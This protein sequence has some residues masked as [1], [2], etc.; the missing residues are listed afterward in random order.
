LTPLDLG[1]IVQLG[2][3]TFV[4]A[5]MPSLDNQVANVAINDNTPEPSLS[6]VRLHDYPTLLKPTGRLKGFA[7]RP[8][9]NLSVVPVQQHFGTRH[10]RLGR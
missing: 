2:Q 8:Q 10:K 7:H 4:S 9:V 6:S 1:G 3:I 5:P